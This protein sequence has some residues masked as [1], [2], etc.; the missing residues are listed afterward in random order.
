[1]ETMEKDCPCTCDKTEACDCDSENHA[2][3]DIEFD[4]DNFAKGVNSASELCGK[5]AALMS[6]GIEG[7]TALNYLLERE[8]NIRAMKTQVELARMGVPSQLD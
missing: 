1:M 5:L 4:A 6:V 3:I 7:E 8:L 2:T